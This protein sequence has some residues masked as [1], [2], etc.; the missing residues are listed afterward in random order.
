MQ[1]QKTRDEELK[2][3]YD[4]E[5]EVYDKKRFEDFIGSFYN[6]CHKDTVKKIIRLTRPANNILEIAPGTGRL[7]FL[8]TK[9][10]SSVT[11]VDISEKMLAKLKAKHKSKNLKIKVGN[12]QKLPFPDNHFDMV[13]SFRFLHLFKRNKLFPYIK[14]MRR[15]L[16]PGGK[17][18]LEFNN[19][20]AGI[21]LHYLYEIRRP[22][23]KRENYV[24]PSQLKRIVKG[25]TYMKWYGVG[26][27]CGLWLIAKLSDR[28]ARSIHSFFGMSPMKFFACQIIMVWKKKK[29]KNAE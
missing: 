3:I 8:L 21:F 23:E 20:F 1:N 19:S 6:R 12:A 29:K 26:F 16:K 15:V 17:L 5:S 25:I 14:E 2:R 7:T 18:V 22:N 11:A 27:P 24:R 10:Y 28:A 9:N 4:K 13:Y